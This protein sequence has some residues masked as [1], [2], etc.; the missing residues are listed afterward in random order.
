MGFER[1]RFRKPAIPAPGAT[2]QLLIDV[3]RMFYFVA[4]ALLC[5]S[6]DGMQRNIAPAQPSHLPNVI[7]LVQTTVDIVS[8]RSS[9]T[10]Q[11]SYMALFSVLTACEQ[12]GKVRL[13]GTSRLLLWLIH[14]AATRILV[15]LDAREVSADG[16]GYR[17]TSYIV[18]LKA[19][20][21]LEANLQRLS[22]AH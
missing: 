21:D 2:R 9:S 20:W 4:A 8:E 5:L 22:R 15:G 14:K 19:L 13:D 3:R 16:V 1:T 17:D 12:L 6:D 11:P 7:A 18:L 10:R